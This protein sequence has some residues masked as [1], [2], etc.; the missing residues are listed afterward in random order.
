MDI[1]GTERLRR[2]GG[3]SVFARAQQEEEA[4]A[5]HVGESAG[6][7]VGGGV[8]LGKDVPQDRNGNGFD[9]LGRRIGTRVAG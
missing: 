3:P 8:G 2:W 9:T 4:E 7:G 6:N 1:A 5:N